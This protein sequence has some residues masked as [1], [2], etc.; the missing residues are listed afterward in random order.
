VVPVQSKSVSS[1][2]ATATTQALVLTAPATA[3]NLICG[4]V[5]WGTGNTAHLTSVTDDAGNTYTIQRRVLD[6][7][8]LTVIA[9]FYKENITGT[10]QTITANFSTA[11]PFRAVFAHEVPGCAS[12]GALDV[13]TGQLQTAPGTGANAVSSGA[14][15]TTV[16]GDYIYGGVVCTN[17]LF[18]AANYSPGTS[19]N[20]FTERQETFGATVAASESEDFV[21]TTKGSI[22]ATWTQANAAQAMSVMMAFFAATAGELG[23][24]S[25]RHGWQNSYGARA[26]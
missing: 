5:T 22:A 17:Q 9:S 10:P 11:V 4:H 18:G 12:S 19:P 16:D 6:T 25:A 21:Q 23:A 1:T 13:E 14:V 7:P 3:G 26:A 24:M 15:T 8:N 20:A 2:S